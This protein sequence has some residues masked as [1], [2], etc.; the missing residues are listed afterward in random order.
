VVL[1]R[2]VN[3]LVNGKSFY[4]YHNKIFRFRHERNRA[5][6][7]WIY[8]LIKEMNKQY[9]EDTRKFQFR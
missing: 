6:N 2:C 8:R 7:N 3:L 9:K 1:E 5:I 4:Y